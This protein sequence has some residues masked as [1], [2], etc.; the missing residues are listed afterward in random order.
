MDACI[1]DYGLGN[2]FNLQK[3]ARFLGVKVE[4]SSD[5]NKV[6]TANKLILPGVGAFEDGM[7][8]LKKA[9]L[10]IAI[11]DFIQTGKPFLGICLGM[12]LLMQESEENG[13]FEGLGI[14]PGRV[15]RLQ[16]SGTQKMC[17]KIPHVGWN[18]ILYPQAKNGQ[19]RIWDDT[20]L[21]NL[22]EGSYFYFV[23]SYQVIPDDKSVILSETIYADNR[24][25][26][27][28]KSKNVYA[29]QFHPE[30]SAG[31]GLK[32]IDNFFKLQGNG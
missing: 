32:G 12:Q 31:D 29:C 11:K 30:M 19:P 15:V 4:V 21:K 27:V 9:G 23:H 14:I 18:K 6:R 13:V 3:A 28:L 20:I 22:K 5:P 26:S 25:C 2:L 16:E 1:I 24:F 7:N 17:V 8:N 10:D